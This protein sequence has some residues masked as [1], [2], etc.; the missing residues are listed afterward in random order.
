[1]M[2]AAL[3]LWKT[4]VA[5]TPKT[6]KEIMPVLMNTLISSLASTSSERQHVAARALGE[7]VRKLG[8][9]VLPLIIP[10]LSQ[11]LKDPNA[12]RR[13]VKLLPVA[14]VVC[15]LSLLKL[16]SPSILYNKPNPTGKY[17]ASCASN[18]QRDLDHQVSIH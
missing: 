17:K 12:G 4:I 6:F 8:E 16:P 18:L 9:R 14:A 7:L 1:M 2:K 3:H 15:P 11:G 10:I 5:N 13:Q